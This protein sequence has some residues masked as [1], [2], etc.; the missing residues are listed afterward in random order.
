MLVLCVGGWLEGGT[1]EAR[2]ADFPSAQLSLWWANI[3]EQLAQFSRD[4]LRQVNPL[5]RVRAATSANDAQPRER[6]LGLMFHRL[7]PLAVFEF[8]T[9]TT[10]RCHLRFPV[11]SSTSLRGKLPFLLF[12]PHSSGAEINLQK[13]F[14]LAR[15]TGPAHPKTFTMNG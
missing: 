5:A 13:H 8:R 15:L 1:I 2:A 10:F 7:D 3:A 9:T 11:C 4:G 12:F 6:E 14:S